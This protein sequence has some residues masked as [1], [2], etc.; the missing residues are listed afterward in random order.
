[1]V[2]ANTTEKMHIVKA[3]LCIILLYF[4]ANE[5]VP[6]F[7]V[8]FVINYDYVKLQSVAPKLRLPFLFN[9]NQHLENFSKT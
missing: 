7:E 4:V 2:L 9:V 5:H 3:D 6:L 8:F 1:M